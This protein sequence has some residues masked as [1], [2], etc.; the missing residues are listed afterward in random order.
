ME[1]IDCGSQLQIGSFK[2]KNPQQNEAD[3]SSLMQKLQIA[4]VGREDPSKDGDSGISEDEESSGDEVGD[5][6][7]ELKYQ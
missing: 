4:V 3:L 7:E 5:I 2:V 6:D 1:E